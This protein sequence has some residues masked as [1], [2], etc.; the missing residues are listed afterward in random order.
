MKG[1]GRYV[2]SGSVLLFFLGNIFQVYAEGANLLA[3][4]LLA[5]FAPFYFG[6]S[7]KNSNFAS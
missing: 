3:L 2:V 6:I 7:K 5:T 4:A 1:C